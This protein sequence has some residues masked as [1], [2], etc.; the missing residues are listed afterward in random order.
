M[1]C[2]KPN[3]RLSIHQML[4]HPWFHSSGASNSSAA[5][6]PAGNASTSPRG[7]VPVRHVSQLD[8]SPGSAISSTAAA[9][10]TPLSGRSPT[11]VKSHSTSSASALS[12]FSTNGCSD[13]SLRTTPVVARPLSA[14][15]EGLASSASSQQSP[16]AARAPVVTV[17]VSLPSLS[18]EKPSGNRSPERAFAKRSSN[19]SSH[20]H[21]HTSAE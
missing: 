1:L 17:K 6:V 7:S 16:R 19:G 18:P 11:K 4:D 21:H 14:E 8:E 5:A 20:H 9:A 13:S 3:E 10:I 12:P 15:L 2:E